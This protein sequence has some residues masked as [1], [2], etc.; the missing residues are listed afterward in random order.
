MTQSPSN[1]LNRSCPGIKKSARGLLRVDKVDG[2]YALTDRVTMDQEQGGELKT[3]FLD[4][5]LYRE[6]TLS[7]IRGVLNE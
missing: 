1:E 6:Q 5:T 4:G 3:V 2:E 7:E